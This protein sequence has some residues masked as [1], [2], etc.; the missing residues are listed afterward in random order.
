MILHIFFHY[1]NFVE[2]Y[3]LKSTIEKFR[4]KEYNENIPFVIATASTAVNICEDFY[5]W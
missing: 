1:V 5:K 4:K 3:L 2:K